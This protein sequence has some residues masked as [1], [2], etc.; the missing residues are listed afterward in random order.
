V[1]PSSITFGLRVFEAPW[2]LFDKMFPSWLDEALVARE[3]EDYREV[4]SITSNISKM[5]S[6]RCFKWK[7]GRRFGSAVR[8]LS[9][10]SSHHALSLCYVK[11]DLGKARSGK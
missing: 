6:Y 3:Q 2:Y 8:I 10:G 9:L 7:M 1:D 5:L 4:A 11:R